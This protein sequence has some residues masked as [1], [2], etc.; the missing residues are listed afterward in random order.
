MLIF[1][2]YALEGFNHILL[3][4]CSEYYNLG[5]EFDHLLNL[6]TILSLV[7]IYEILVAR[8]QVNNFV[9]SCHFPF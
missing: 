3:N 6:L 7:F 1:S 2:L 5:N 8:D 9:L 4:F